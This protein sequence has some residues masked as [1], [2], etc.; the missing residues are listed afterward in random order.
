MNEGKKQMDKQAKAWQP[1]FVSNTFF[2]SFES[3]Q[4]Y[5]L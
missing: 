2:K 4:S 1:L 3:F 5:S